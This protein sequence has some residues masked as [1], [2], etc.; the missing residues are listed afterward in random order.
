MHRHCISHD[1]SAN[2]RLSNSTTLGNVDHVRSLD[3]VMG[4]KSSQGELEDH[5]YAAEN[6]FT[7]MYHSF[8]SLYKHT[9]ND[10][11]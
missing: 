4:V 6:S 8:L 5:I 1:A 9:V 7:E 10:N 3:G 2:N 11:E